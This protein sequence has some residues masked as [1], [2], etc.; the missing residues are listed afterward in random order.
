MAGRNFSPAI[1]GASSSMLPSL[2][3]PL[4][5]GAAA[6]G[7]VD[8]AVGPD[9]GLGKNNGPIVTAPGRRPRRSSR[10]LCRCRI[11]AIVSRA[12][13]KRAQCADFFIPAAVHLSVLRHRRGVAGRHRTLG[14]NT[15]PTWGHPARRS[16]RSGAARCSCAGSHGRLA[17]RSFA[18][19]THVASG[20]DR[21]LAHR[22]NVDRSAGRD[23]PSRRSA[24]RR[25]SRLRCGEPALCTNH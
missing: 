21:K 8:E 22:T 5:A 12:Y 13:R 23:R 9:L 7:V 1:S 17:A 10:P 24:S 14:S 4:G 15:G 25:Y 18:C 16:P 2:A 3:H 6:H 19:G 11:G 20:C